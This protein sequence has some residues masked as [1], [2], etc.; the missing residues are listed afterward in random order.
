[1]PPASLVHYTVSSTYV[2]PKELIDSLVLDKYIRILHQLPRYRLSLFRFQVQ[3]QTIVS[4]R[5]T[6]GTYDLLFRFA[7]KKYADSGGRSGRGTVLSVERGA[8]G[9]N[10]D[11]VSSPFKGDSICTSAPSNYNLTTH[12]DDI[13]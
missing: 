2:S 1:M 5:S 13:G 12:L 7:C 3:S 8:K 10:Q 4:P 6:L 11:L 9:G